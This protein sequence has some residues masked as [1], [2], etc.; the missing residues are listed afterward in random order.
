[1]IKKALPIAVIGLAAL[2][3]GC[4][5]Q[6]K[7]TQDPRHPY[8]FQEYEPNDIRRKSYDPAWKDAVEEIVRDTLD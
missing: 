2:I 4:A 1:M 7:R 5:T 3:N 8:Y 6:E